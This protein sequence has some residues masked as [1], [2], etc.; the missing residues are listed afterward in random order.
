MESPVALQRFSKA[1]HCFTFASCDRGAAHAIT[2]GTHSWDINITSRSIRQTMLCSYLWS[3]KRISSMYC[4]NR[5]YTQLQDSS[6]LPSFTRPLLILPHTFLQPIKPPPSLKCLLLCLIPAHHRV[7]V[8]RH[9][10]SRDLFALPSHV[11]RQMF[12]QLSNSVSREFAKPSKE[13]HECLLLLLKRVE[14]SW[15][16]QH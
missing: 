7:H 4:F 2:R 8:S 11:S 9:R 3:S 1:S 10:T 12:A 5:A 15:S 14:A 16:E 6:R 13:G